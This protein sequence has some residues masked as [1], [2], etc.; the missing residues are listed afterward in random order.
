MKG[1]I[2]A[3]SYLVIGFLSSLADAAEKR[4][5]AESTVNDSKKERSVARHPANRA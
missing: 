2:A 1:C 3:S 5:S 4:N